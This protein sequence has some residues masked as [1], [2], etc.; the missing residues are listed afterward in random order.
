MDNLQ[1]TN[2]AE[3]TEDES[4]WFRVFPKPSLEPSF[5]EKLSRIGRK[6][7]GNPLFR[8]VWGGEE[9]IYIE[10]D[11]DVPS[12]H[13]H[14][15][16]I[17][18]TF[19]KLKGYSYTQDGEEKFISSL[20]VNAEIPSDVLVKP[21]YEFVSV[22]RPRWVIEVWRDESEPG[23]H[24]SGYYEAWTVQTLQLIDSFSGRQEFLSTY[25][26]PAEIDLQMAEHAAHLMETLTQKDI[27]EG[28]A[29]ED[30]A[31]QLK[32]EKEI[33]E[34]F[35]I[36]K[37]DFYKFLVDGKK[38]EGYDPEEVDLNSLLKDAQKQF[39]SV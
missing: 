21:V 12:G 24:R 3:F 35:E 26:E 32:K 9:E 36:D 38:D 33:D 39:A 15:Y 7:E 6:R 23:I 25:R 4:T 8:I 11:E 17:G 34:Q 29:A 30:A 14:R 27:R 18:S 22:G 2:Y 5:R 37:E 10:G 28:I 16:Q 1:I 20:D 13:Y 19:E 31:K